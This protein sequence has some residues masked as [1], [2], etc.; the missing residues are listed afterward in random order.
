MILALEVK[1]EQEDKEKDPE[2]SEKGEEEENSKKEDEEKQEKEKEE[3]PKESEK[4][5]DISTNKTECDKERDLSRKKVKKSKI[6]L[7]AHRLILASC[8]PLIRKILDNSVNNS[9][10]NLTIYFPGKYFLL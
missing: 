1:T 10:D 3:E 8:S 6:L 9:M 2:V 7:K 4:K 5:E